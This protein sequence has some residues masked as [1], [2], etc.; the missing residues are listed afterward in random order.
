VDGEASDR[1]IESPPACCVWPCGVAAPR[2]FVSKSLNSR[3]WCGGGFNP[4][5]KAALPLPRDLTSAGQPDVHR[6]RVPHSHESG[7]LRR[8]DARA[9][10]AWGRRCWPTHSGASGSAARTASGS[11]STRRATPAHS[12]S[13]SAPGWR[14]RSAGW[15]TRRSS[16]MR[17]SQGAECSFARRAEPLE[18]KRALLLSM[19]SESAASN[20]AVWPSAASVG[21][22]RVDRG[23][24]RRAP[25]IAGWRGC[26]EGARWHGRR[27]WGRRR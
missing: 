11:E 1:R 20:A 22:T 19:Q 10:G 27:R 8:G 7:R 17:A 16:A 23:A 24:G 14:P 13:T 12:G 5:C 15:R 26:A 25:R 2:S 4:P 6:M 3:R 18:H 21:L 9:S